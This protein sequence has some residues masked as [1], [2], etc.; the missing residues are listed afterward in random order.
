MM[1]LVKLQLLA[2]LA[3]VVAYIVRIVQARHFS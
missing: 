3:L 1:L 2:T